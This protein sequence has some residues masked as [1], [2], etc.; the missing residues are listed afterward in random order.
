MNSLCNDKELPVQVEAGI[1]INHILGRDDVGGKY[2]SKNETLK[3]VTL[4]GILMGK[5]NGIRDYCF[6]SVVY[7]CLLMIFGFVF[8]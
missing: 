7:L 4:I 8:Q 6:C 3:H 5:N 1:A 2:R